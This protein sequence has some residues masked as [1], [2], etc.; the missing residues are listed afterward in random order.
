MRRADVS[1]VL[2][3]RSHAMGYPLQLSARYLNSKKGAFISVG[4]AFAVIG[5]ALGVAAL[6]GI[7]GGLVL[8]GASHV[9][10]LRQ[11]AQVLFGKF[12]IGHSQK[13]SF[14]CGLASRVAEAENGRRGWVVRRLRISTYVSQKQNRKQN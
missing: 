5:V 8:D 4:T 2:R 9:R 6:A 3:R 11:D 1:H 13:S 10:R 14:Y 12:R 7:G